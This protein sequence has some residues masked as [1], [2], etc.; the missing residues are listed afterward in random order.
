MMLGL[1]AS[2]F[3]PKL[4]YADWVSLGVAAR[5]DTA[6]NLFSLIPV[7]NTSSK[8]FDINPPKGFKKFKEGEKQRYVCKLGGAQIELLLRVYG[9]QARGMGQGAGVIIISSL[10]IGQN[11]LIREETNFNWQVMDERVLTKVLVKKYRD[12][13]ETE[14]CYSNG[15]GWD[16]PYKDLQCSSTMYEANRM[17]GRDAREEQPRAPQHGR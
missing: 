6:T 7:V 17:F 10:R 3:L 15:W 13:Y 11:E 8:E 5:C 14:L 4:A 9:P 12:K 16:A 2:T 1:I